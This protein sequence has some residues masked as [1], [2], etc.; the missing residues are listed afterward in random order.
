MVR[1]V[2]DTPRSD[3]ARDFFVELKEKLKARFKQ[4]D[5]WITAFEIETI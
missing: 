1:F 5:I 3:D 4:L 2:V